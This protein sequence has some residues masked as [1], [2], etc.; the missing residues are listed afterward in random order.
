MRPK[1]R[2]L[3]ALVASMAAAVCRQTSGS[4]DAR[5]FGPG[6]GCLGW[7]IPLFKDECAG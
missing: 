1:A 7:D 5:Q 2:V 6:P 3:Y 4:H